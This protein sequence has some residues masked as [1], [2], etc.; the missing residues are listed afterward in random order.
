[1]KKRRIVARGYI[2]FRSFNG[3]DAGNPSESISLTKKKCWTGNVMG[4]PSDRKI[5]LIAEW[6][7]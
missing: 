4:V 3:S 2:S 6:G 1:M 7:R 5:R